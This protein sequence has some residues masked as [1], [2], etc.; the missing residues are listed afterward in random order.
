MVVFNRESSMDRPKPR[1]VKELA[2][3]LAIP[4]IDLLLPCNFC[5][6]FLSYFELLSFDYKYLQLIWTV[7]DLV[8]AICSSCAFASAQHEFMKYF[9]YSVVGKQIE[10]VANQPIGNI[11][12]RC[13]Y[14]LKKLDLVEKLG[15]CYKQQ[16]FHRVRDNWKGLCRLCGSVE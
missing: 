14:C 5:N 7:E 15:V 12:V 4:V 8:Y 11:T 9:E 13:Q 3:T 16:Y 6:R 1:T 10:T 2:D